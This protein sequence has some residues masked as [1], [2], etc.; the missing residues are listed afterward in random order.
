[1]TTWP[2]LPRDITA[3]PVSTVMSPDVLVV[4]LQDPGH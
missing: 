1:M 4:G 2:D 3:V